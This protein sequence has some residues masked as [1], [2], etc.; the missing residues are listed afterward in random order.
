M[1]PSERVDGARL[2]Q[3]LMDL[4][5]FGA[6]DDGG[7][8]RQALSDA[9]IEAKVRNCAVTGSPGSWCIVR[10]MGFKTPM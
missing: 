9:E 3:R 2:W 1:R 4:A 5:R 8:D 6:R 7:V 10:A